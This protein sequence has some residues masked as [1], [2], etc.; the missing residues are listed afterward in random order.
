MPIRFQGYWLVTSA[1]L[2][3]TGASRIC[4]YMA[5]GDNMVFAHYNTRAYAMI[6]IFVTHVYFNNGII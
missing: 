6:P 1:F 5:A 3:Y 4:Y 2:G